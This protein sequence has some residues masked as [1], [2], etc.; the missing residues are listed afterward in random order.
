MYEEPD[1]G[2]Q[3]SQPPPWLYSL[4]EL[5]RVF[6]EA[7]SLS[8]SWPSL[9]AS[10]PRGDG[11][12]V[13]ALPGFAAGDG[14]T[15]VLRRFLTRLGYNALPWLLGP[16]RGA[17]VQLHSLMRR[18][19]RLA[20]TYNEPISIVGQ[21]L[22]GIYGRELAREFPGS[23][24]GVITLGSPFAATSR[25]S[26]N[27]LVA[28]LFE[29][30]SGVSVEQMRTEMAREDSRVPPPVPVTAVYSKSDGVVNWHGCME[31]E[32]DKT[33]N[34]EVVGSHSGMA[35]HP[36]VLHV[37]ADRLGQKRGAWRKFERKRGWRAL[38]YPQPSR[39][40]PAH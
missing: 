22:G 14:S 9:M 31:V 35:M 36:L 5:P 20:Q 7:A 11:H 21:S 34:I 19:Y 28:R 27:P 3:A 37:I 12:P 6:G 18:F 26:T 38:V 15:L 32:T 1:L 17:P 29:R 13:L 30:M 24:R 2:P 23:V 33:E 39:P 25:Q 10:A 8:L 4:A 40:P 16:N